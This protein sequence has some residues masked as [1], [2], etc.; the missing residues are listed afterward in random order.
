MSRWEGGGQLA[1]QRSSR[2]GVTGEGVTSEGVTGEGV[3]GEG[4]T[5]E[6]VTGKGCSAVLGARA[7]FRR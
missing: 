2:E 4:V 1:D 6:G 5:G 7:T 3:T